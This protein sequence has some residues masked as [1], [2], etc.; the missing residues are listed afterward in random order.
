MRSSL[1][2]LSSAPT[3]AEKPIRVMLV[4][5][6]N[7]VRS[8]FAR[9]LGDCGEVEI[10]G[11]AGNS[12]EALRLLPHAQP[13]IILLDIE[14]PERSGLDALP[15]ILDASNGARV[16]V[17]SSFAEENG[18]AAIRALELGAC[19]TLAKPGRF[20]FAG[21]FP[22]VLVEKVVRLGNSS[23]M[24]PARKATPASEYPAIEI[25]DD[26]PCPEAIAI[27][28]STG[29]I[30]I[31]YEIIRNLPANLDC[32]VFIAQHLPDAF[33]EF[34]AR[35]LSAQTDRHVCVPKA[36]A[37]IMDRTI[38]VS[39]GSVHLTCIQAGRRRKIGH[40]EHYSG[41]RYSPSV[42]ALFSSVAKIYGDKALAIV[43]SGMGNDGAAG[44]AHLSRAGAKVIAQDAETSV[45]WGMPGA[46]A[47][48]GLADAVLP[49]AQISRLLA[50][51]A[52][53]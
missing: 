47:K 10:V 26:F 27:G 8:I 42:D 7:V 23:R 48:A 31:I 45:V 53:R 43:L 16:L 25:K 50:R 14:M 5:D 46:V 32:P 41:S 34:F 18:P 30:P 40:L 9:M 6:S 1:N 22:D 37:E 29:G 3:R 28:A 38:Y 51:A 21:R 36:G 4:D 17:V 15:D 35:Q 12:A 49:P 39:P 20:G 24:F 19:D 2:S 11:E 52:Q 33:M 13:D 44:A